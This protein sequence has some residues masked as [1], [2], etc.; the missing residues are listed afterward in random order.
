VRAGEEVGADHLQAVA[1]DLSEP[2][3]SPAVSIACSI[4]RIWFL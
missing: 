2:S 3:I 4:T 1:R